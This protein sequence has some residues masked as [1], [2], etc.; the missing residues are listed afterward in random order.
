MCHMNEQSNAEIVKLDSLS[1][2]VVTPWS[3][4]GHGHDTALPI[5]T[6]SGS[7]EVAASLLVSL[8]LA[9]QVH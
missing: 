4:L 3:Q 1:A 5:A 8:S 7:S 9:L 6:R 2:S